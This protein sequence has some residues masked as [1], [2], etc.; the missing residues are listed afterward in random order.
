VLYVEKVGLGTRKSIEERTSRPVASKSPC[1]SQWCKSFSKEA[2]AC[3]DDITSW[4]KQVHQ[5]L[6][7]RRYKLCKAAKAKRPGEEE[8]DNYGT[9]EQKS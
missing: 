3:G 8:R 9:N 2:D 1:Q 7:E 6:I 4:K 5:D